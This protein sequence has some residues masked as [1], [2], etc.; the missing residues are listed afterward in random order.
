MFRHPSKS[1]TPW[2]FVLPAII[3]VVAV[4]GVPLIYALYVSF[5]SRSGLSMTFVGLRNYKVL[6]S[7]ERFLNSLT[8][9]LTFSVV[10]VT[11]EFTLGFALA[12]VFDRII[13]AKNW[14][15]SV[16]LL[17]M[18]V[19]P[20]VVGNIWRMLYHPSAGLVNWFLGLIG[21]KGPLWLSS[22]TWAL[23]AVIISDVWQWTPLMFLILLAGLQALPEEPFEAARVDGVNGWQEFRFITVPLMVPVMLVALLMRLLDAIKIFDQ[24]FTLT[25]GGPGTAT[26]TLSFYI[27]KVGFMYFDSGYASALSF[28]FMLLI[29]VLSLAIFRIMSRDTME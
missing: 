23:P 3:L 12:W 15:V 7:D 25:H 6:F 26:E 13:S 28:A 2:L 11:I 27:Y 18:M 10:A 1:L 16:L 29:F 21:I 8:T 17:P 4:I 19:T 5:F 9:S 22:I 24:V 20:I 14:L